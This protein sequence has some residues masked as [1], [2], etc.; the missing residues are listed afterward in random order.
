M[1]GCRQS[2]VPSLQTG[3]TPGPVCR[4]GSS[5]M[6][7]SGVVFR[8]IPTPANQR[9][10]LRNTRSQFALPQAS[11][12]GGR[13]PE[14]GQPRDADASDGVRG[15]VANYYRVPRLSSF[16][17]LTHHGERVD[18]GIAFTRTEHIRPQS[19]SRQHNHGI[20]MTLS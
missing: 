19:V 6:E 5:E 18:L 17:R 1:A 3:P 13:L 10:E 2:L 9:I 11:N 4:P 16:V 15:T 7:G 14:C 20:Q 8:A 12:A